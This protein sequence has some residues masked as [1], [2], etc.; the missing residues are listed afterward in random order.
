[1]A[2]KL[3]QSPK[4]KTTVT[5]NVPNDK[6]TF[7]KNTFVATFKRLT[8]TELDESRSMQNA[9]LVRKV[10]VDWDL[11]DEETS[12]NVPFSAETLEAVLQIAPSPMA[13]AVAFWESVGGARSKN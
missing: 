11:K 4:F 3:T 8:A 7:D 5:V 13:I 1:M 9:D 12:E 10:L 6:G 2:F